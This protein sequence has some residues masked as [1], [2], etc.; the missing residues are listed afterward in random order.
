MRCDVVR[1][2]V[3][4]D[5]IIGIAHARQHKLV[6]KVESDR[7]TDGVATDLG[8]GMGVYKYLWGRAGF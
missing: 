4:R 2:D 1:C 8:R 5:V 3:V 7:K 6:Q